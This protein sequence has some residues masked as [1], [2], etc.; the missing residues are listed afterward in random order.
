MTMT[1][2]NCNFIRKDAVTSEKEGLTEY[3]N[4]HEVGFQSHWLRRS[5]E[6]H[7]RHFH[8]T[9]YCHLMCFTKFHWIKERSRNAL[10]DVTLSQCIQ[11]MSRH[12][13]PLRDVVVLIPGIMSGFCRAN[14]P[15]L[16]HHTTGVKFTYNGV[17]V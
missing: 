2:C 6:M 1:T 15:S 5:F 7:H 16:T 3:T 13:L 4:L 12:E 14:T 11:N 9:I 10:Y 17:L 8:S